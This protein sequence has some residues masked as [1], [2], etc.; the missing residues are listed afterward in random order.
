MTTKDEILSLVD[1]FWNEKPPTEFVAGETYI[2]TSGKDLDTK[3]IHSLVAQILTGWLT[4]GPATATFERD[5]LKFLHN[6]TRCAAACNSGSSANLLAVSA[7]TAP[8]FGCRAA[9]PGDEVITTACGFP[10]TLNPIIQNQLIPVFV[11]VCLPTYLPDIKEIEQAITPATKAIFIPHTL[12]NPFDLEAYREMADDAGIWLLSDA[13]DAFGAESNGMQVGTVEDISTLS[14]YPAHQV[15]TG[16]GGVVLSQ[17][18]MVNKGVKSFRDWGRSCWC[19]TGKDDTCG[20]RH[21]QKHGVLPFGYDHKY[22]FS[23]IGYNLKMTDMQA[24]L[25]VEQVRKLPEFVAKRRHNWNYLRDGMEKFEKYFVL[26]EAEK[27][28]YPSWFGFCLTLQKGVHFSRFDLIKHLEAHKV[29]TRLLFGGNLLLHPA[30]KNIKKRIFGRL[31]NS[32]MIAKDTFWIG[33]YQDI[34]DEMMDYMLNIFDLFISAH[35]RA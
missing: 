2:R 27:V 33:C 34:T 22:V 19:L 26:P 3:D 18:P 11:D 20:K 24:A 13:C 25:G 31:D 28:A 32:D 6:Q 30:Y 4:D 5:I 17:S 35:Q 9:N 7:I 15:T 29:G 10:T 16:E 12:G 1:K 14:F 21:S 23:R 8:E